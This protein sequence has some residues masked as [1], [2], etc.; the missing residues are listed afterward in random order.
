MSELFIAV[1]TS[2]IAAEIYAWLPNLSVLLLR[3]YVYFLPKQMGVR[4]LEEWQALLNDTPGN[5]T[6]FL[7]ALDLARTLPLI[8]TDVRDMERSLRVNSWIQDLEDIYLGLL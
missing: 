4:L 1:V 2:I 5:V 8:L 6:K 3:F 7:R